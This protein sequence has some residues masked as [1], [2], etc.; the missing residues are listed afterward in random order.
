M[1]IGEFGIGPG[2]L[3]NVA[4]HH[5]LDGVHQLHIRL[6]EGTH[7]GE[8]MYREPHGFTLPAYRGNG[9]LAA[10]ILR[11]LEPISTRFAEAAQFREAVIPLVTDISGGDRLTDIWRAYQ[12]FLDLVHRHVMPLAGENGMARV[13]AGPD[14]LHVVLSV[15]AWRPDGRHGGHAGGP[16]AELTPADYL[17]SIT[18]L[19][20]SRRRCPGGPT[21]NE[22]VAVRIAYHLIARGWSPRRP[23]RAWGASGFRDRQTYLAVADPGPG[24]LRCTT[25]DAA[26]LAGAAVHVERPA[27]DAADPYRIPALKTVARV[28]LHTGADAPCSCHV[29][30]P[31]FAGDAAASM[32]EGVR[33][34]NGVCGLIFNEGLAECKVVIE[35]MT[36]LQAI[37]FMRAVAAHVRRD[38]LRQLL[39]ASV[40]LNTPLLD[41]RPATR[42]RNDGR[43]VLVADRY[44]VGMLAVEMIRA[45][46][47]DKVVWDG[48]GGDRPEQCVLEQLTHEEAVRL[49]HRAHEAGLPA[50]FAAGIGPEHVPLAV[51]TGVDGAVVGGLVRYTDTPP[52]VEEEIAGLLRLRDR[53][54]A[55]V[56]GRAA[57]LLARLDRMR[58]EGSITPADD[59]LRERLFTAVA[60][61]DEDAMRELV[62]VMRHVTALP[63][64]GDH[65]LI[66]SAVRLI[67]AGHGSRAAHVFGESWDTRLGGLTE[68]VAE[69]DLAILAAELRTICEAAEPVPERRGPGAALNV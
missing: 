55:S 39:S 19:L 14:R 24:H 42:E 47:F 10:M 64:D 13:A 25:A 18:Y 60:A 40:N 49:V 32:A 7:A 48:T 33:L 43:P 61:S 36:V 15:P 34:M 37:G 50:C 46:R 9:D 23:Y 1:R 12:A 65:T 28:R 16:V 62:D 59:I 63:P 52:F 3:Q 44:A 5:I 4:L 27:A 20:E 41:D 11:D 30:R 54:A 67:G 66:C 56:P 51:R 57:G 6:A 8:S 35:G 68:L 45:G 22:M 31:M 21:R 53:A 17:D 69:R 26:N 38:P 2:T 58:Y 29:G